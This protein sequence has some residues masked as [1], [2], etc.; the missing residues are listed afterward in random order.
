M[1][2][3]TRDLLGARCRIS[4]VLGVALLWPLLPAQAAPA[5][6]VS[7]HEAIRMA[8]RRAPALDALTA[9]L[10]AAEQEAVRAGALPDPT[11]MVG[12]ENWP[13]TG[14][15]AFALDADMMT[16]QRI[17]VRQEF[18]AR[19][20]R[21]ARQRLAS[22]NVD[23]AEALALAER[24]AVQRAVAEA[25]T[26]A[27]AAHR[28]LDALRALR[29]EAALAS[30][31]T[32]A[33][34]AGGGDSAAEALGAEAAVLELDN[35]L[36]ALEADLRGAQATLERWVGEGA[37]VDREAPEAFASL[38]TEQASLLANLDRL[39]PVLA[40]QA[41]LEAV[42]AE[43]DLARAEKSPDWTVSASYGHRRGGASDMLMLE[44]AI[45]LPLFTTNRQDRGITAREAEYHAALASREDARRTL[46]A[47]IVRRVAEWEGLRGQ[48]RRDREQL[49]PLARDRSAV[50]LAAYRG[51][52]TLQPWLAARRDELE[53]ITAHAGRLRALGQVWASLAF[54]L[55]NPSSHMTQPERS[56]APKA[57]EPGALR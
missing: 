29:E 7:L 35:R 33:R 11:L 52:A 23:Q 14:A 2:R 28:E 1:F 43:V 31:L 22:R 21:E 5:T 32:R 41:R 20:K 50:A 55:P 3:S 53:T 17:G 25:W 6:P 37:T 42:A 19:S 15:D 46:A 39:G 45:D 34:V 30:R 48:T 26:D 54:L 9:Q 10:T 44:F 12:I 13:V 27:W 57:F 36:Q 16:M 8:V 47:E 56:E 51:G 49:L 4:L 40:W 18:P 24:L 38:P